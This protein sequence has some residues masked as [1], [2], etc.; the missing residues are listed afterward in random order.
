M[1][2]LDRTLR[3][4]LENTV[5][6]ARR[7]A[8]A[9]ARKAIESLAV[10]HH[11]PHSSMTSTQRTLR[12]RLRAH[13]RQLGDRRDERR[14]TQTIERLVGE[15]AYEHWHRMLFAR[16]L[17]ENDLLIE[18][19]HGVPI[20][21]DDCRELAREQGRD[22]LELASTYAVRMLPQI[23]RAD[24]PVL[25]V[26]LPPETRSEL[27]DLLKAL[28]REVFLADDSLGWVYQFWQ[29][30]QKDAVNASGNKI[31]ADE[32]P[33][34]TQLFTEDYMVEFLLHNTL[35]A[36]W[37]GKVLASNPDL[38]KNAKDEDELRAICAVGD[39]RWTYLRFVREDGKPWWPAAGVFEHWPKTA[40]K[41]KVLDP[42]CGSGH[43]LVFALLILMQ[44]RMAE[45]GL[46]AREACDAVLRENLFGLELDSR[47]TQIAAFNLALVAWKSTE[48]RV[49]P[50]LQVACSGLSVGASK[51]VWLRT[52][53]GS[54]KLAGG[55]ARLYDI[56]LLAPTLGSLIDPRAGDTEAVLFEATFDELDPLL[57][58]TINSTQRDDDAR[59]VR[60]AASDLLV[61]MRILASQHTLVAT[62]VP[63]LARV[64]QNDTLREFSESWFPA[65]KQDIS[66]VFFG[67]CLNLANSGTVAVVTPQNW[68]FLTNY[69]KF[70]T[71]L[72]QECTFHL[73]VALG[74]AAFN[75][76]NWWAA[77]TALTVVSNTCPQ[78]DR[79]F[80]V[81]DVAQSRDPVV[82]AKEVITE[83][84]IVMKQRSQLSN[85][86]A[87]I[88]MTDLGDDPL[89]SS[90]AAGYQGVSPAD[91]PHF[92]R[93]FWE[94]ILDSDWILW[95]GSV[96]K[97]DHY[98][99]R[100]QVLWIGEDFQQ[101][102][103][104][105]SA[106]W[107]G[108]E[109][110]GKQGVVINAM[111]NLPVT[112]YTG[113][114]HDTNVV[115]V[116][117][118]ADDCVPSLW[119][120]C[121]APEYRT[122]VREVDQAL[123]VTNSTMV[124]VPF[125]ID[126]WQRVTSQNYPHGLPEPYSDDPT[127]WIFHGHP[128]GSVRWNE[129]TKRL[130]VASKPRADATVLQVAVA[131]LLGYRWSAEQDAEMRLSDESR[132]V[133]ARCSELHRFADKDGIVCLSPIHKEAP[134]A[135]RLTELLAAA[136]GEHWSAARLDELLAASESKGKALDDWLRDKFFDQH[137]AVFHHRPF[138]WHIWDGLRDGFNV[139]V[140]YHKLAAPNGEGR[141]TLEKLIYTYL[142]DWVTQQ[143]REQQSGAEGADA[144]LAAALHLQNELKK[145]LEGEP[146][147]DHFV[148]WKPLHEQP[149]G[150][151]PDMND[152]V[153]LNIRPFMTAR[154]LNARAKNACILRTT[155]KIKWDKDRGK[156]P[157]R[158][159]EDYPWFWSWDEKAPDFPG[160]KTFDGNRWND[161][162]YTNAFKKA[163]R[164]RKGRE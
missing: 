155:P 107:R 103:A 26:S 70:R 82:K 108:R 154:P 77:N 43:F 47:C 58:K 76:M 106:Y 114:P 133:M 88:L 147:Y 139:L 28:P 12:N 143:R 62:N 153:R 104:D 140:N 94:G 60:V 75:D 10:H 6:Q 135:Q 101:A 161:L 63:Y 15:C 160:G 156:E 25:E 71:S 121:S 36:W 66:T 111:N 1:A 136:Y 148:R 112:L 68:F 125:D 53:E 65:A 8:E 33:A 48:Y 162:H 122:L 115:T 51:E 80:S 120:F 57:N 126:H 92:A 4:Q 42:C 5:K 17:A 131:R 19:E 30:E 110:Q 32:L 93:K 157:E 41:L 145:I 21:L 149:I 123:K 134:A 64:K 129:E 159:K 150:W 105:G 54:P 56:F 90:I 89:L 61:A 79:S 46:S 16:F 85:P 84:P 119:S 138:I 7:V 151:D 87:R 50:P 38:A 83:R 127:H 9:G 40:A 118:R 44:M 141:R 52:A 29:A 99:G 116:I 95:Q 144:R 98:S 2:S 39:V 86:D 3:R 45:E 24:D 37:A 18:P 130:E 55:L 20:S 59:E 81:L 164:E 31:G 142:G 74:P 146:P 97:T 132:T 49:L 102:L 117:P 73:A 91:H 35:G 100:S 124:K 109:A 158:L 67:R 11:E 152:G 113:Q 23:F 163:A 72:L 13:G 14:G 78:T 34:V 22:W 96:D 27:E 69:R 137:C 128:C